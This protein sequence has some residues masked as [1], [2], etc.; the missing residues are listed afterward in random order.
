MAEGA[1]LLSEYRVQTLSGVRIPSSPP[2]L[3]VAPRDSCGVFF[4]RGRTLHC[5]VILVLPGRWGSYVR[6]YV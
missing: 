3:I 2:D 5:F 6:F 4:Y 1:R